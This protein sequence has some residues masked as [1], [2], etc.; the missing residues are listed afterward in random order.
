MHSL[1]VLAVRVCSNHDELGV[2]V[3]AA[4]VRHLGELLQMNVMTTSN[5][6]RTIQSHA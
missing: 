1:L 5:K 4:G 6:L 2:L 3:K